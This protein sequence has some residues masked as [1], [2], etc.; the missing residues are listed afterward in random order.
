[1]KVIRDNFKKK[2]KSPTFIVLGSFDGIHMGHKALIKSAIDAAD[3][4][5]K[6]IY[7]E[8]TKAEVMVCTFKNHPLSTINKDLVPKL[9]MSNKE[10]VKVLEEL[11][12][13]IVNLMDF[14]KEFMKIS[15]KDFILNLKRY[16]N[17]QGI[18]VG[19]NYRFGYKNLGDV[20]LLRELSEL[21]NF[22]LIVVEP[23]I[24]DDEVVSSSAMIARYL[25]ISC[26]LT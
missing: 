13:D 7:V 2:S 25:S 4:Y 11:G 12:V 14:N 24:V 26:F 1:M 20:D 19:F 23:I 16:Y 15:P 6:D 21:L 10:K 3:E 9:I 5:N 18:I 22:K 8:A 17:A